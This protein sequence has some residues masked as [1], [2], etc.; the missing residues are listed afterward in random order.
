M[1]VM[2]AGQFEKRPNSRQLVF[3][4]EVPLA[5]STRKRLVRETKFNIKK[6]TGWNANSYIHN[7]VRTRC[8][9]AVQDDSY[10]ATRSPPSKSE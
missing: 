9:V 3:R 8:D 1:S 10:Y 7:E 5:P 6:Y 4:P 2:H